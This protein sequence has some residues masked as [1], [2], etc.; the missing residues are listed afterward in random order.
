MKDKETVVVLGASPKPERYSN[1]AVAMLLECDYDVIPVNPSGAT[2]HG[3]AAAKSLDEIKSEVNTLTMYVGA[4]ISSAREAAILKLNPERVI[5][6]PGSENPALESTLADAG[7]K[8]IHACTLVLLR[9]GQ[10]DGA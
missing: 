10:F 6:N 2:V 9:T 5:F 8:V 7:I 4:Q 3:L 1:Q